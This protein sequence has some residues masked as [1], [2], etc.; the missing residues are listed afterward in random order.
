M[1]KKIY[2]KKVFL[3]FLSCK[4]FSTNSAR[5]VFDA[6]Q[7]KLI[8]RGDRLGFLMS[9][10]HRLEIFNLKIQLIISASCES[11]FCLT[12]KEPFTS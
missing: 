4:P 12:E 3:Q 9:F 7:A 11:F 8:L 10:T 1:V 2:T 5:D 6:L